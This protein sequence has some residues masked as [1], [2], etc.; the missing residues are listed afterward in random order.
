MKEE[1]KVI[2]IECALT[3][4]M[5]TE[6]ELSYK[7]DQAMKTENESPLFKEPVI[8]NCSKCDKSFAYSSALKKHE[9][10]HTDEKPFSCSKCDKAFRDS[11]NLKTHERIHTDE[12]P[13]SCSKCDKKFTSVI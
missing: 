9:K 12:K 8:F 10:I 3:E 6:V 1:N 13:F 5:T 2:E 4:D 11:G 7:S